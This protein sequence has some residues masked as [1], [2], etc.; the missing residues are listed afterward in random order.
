LTVGKHFKISE[1]DRKKL[2]DW[3]GKEELPLA[4]IVKDFGAN[5]NGTANPNEPTKPNDTIQQIY[6]EAAQYLNKLLIDPVDEPTLGR[7]RAMNDK[8]K[9]QNGKDGV[10]PA[11]Q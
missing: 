1:A 9:T 8:I 11:E 5:P 3:D 6:K 7:L 10:S 4:T 2:E